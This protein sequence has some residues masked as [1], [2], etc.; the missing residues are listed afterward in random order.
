MKT[1]IEELENEVIVTLE[2]ELDSDA[3]KEVDDMLKPYYINGDKN[4]TVDCEKLVYI[5]SSGLRIMLTILKKT[6]ATGKKMVLRHPSEN[7][8]NIFKVTGFINLF[9]IE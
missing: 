8:K 9:N 3:S 1:K 4:I 7:V 5:A 6:K 2:G